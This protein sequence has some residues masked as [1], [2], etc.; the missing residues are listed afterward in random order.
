MASTS[1]RRSKSPSLFRRSGGSTIIVPNLQR[2]V[3]GAHRETALTRHVSRVGHR[4][5]ALSP[6]LSRVGHAATWPHASE[7][8]SQRQRGRTRE[9]DSLRR[10]LA[11]SVRRLA[12]HIARPDAISVR[13]DAGLHTRDGCAPPKAQARDALKGKNLRLRPL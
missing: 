2:G 4:E 9:R 1:Q 13:R 5:T 10:V 11:C 3:W 6:L 7:R 8:D 12:E